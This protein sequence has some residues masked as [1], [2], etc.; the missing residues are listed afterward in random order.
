MVIRLICANKKGR[1]KGLVS[2]RFDITT[3]KLGAPFKNEFCGNVLLL[4]INAKI[5]QITSVIPL[6]QVVAASV[7]VI[8]LLRFQFC[9]DSENQTKRNKF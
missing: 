7:T 3:D 9:L 8:K 5:N 1:Q 2:W 4:N 6:F